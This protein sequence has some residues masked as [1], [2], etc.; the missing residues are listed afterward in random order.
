MLGYCSNVHAATTLEQVRAALSTHAVAVRDRLGIDGTLPLG[1]WLPASALDTVRDNGSG[2][3]KTW[4]EAHG[5]DVFTING[6]PFGDFH[7][8]VVKHAVYR[9]DWTDPQRP[10]Y[11]LALAELLA[12]LIEP[13]HSGGVS[14]VPLGW[15]PAMD[16][17]AI[18]AA[19]GRL[20]TIAADLERLEE[21]T[22]RCIHV[23]IEPE[24]GCAIERLDGLATFFERHLLGGDDADRIRRYLR[25]CVDCCHAA[26]MY[27]DLHD[28][29]AALD[30]RGIGIGKVQ[31]SNALDV[32]MSEDPGPSRVALQDFRDPRWLHQ[33]MVQDETGTR[34]HED[35][36]L[37][38]DAESGGR[39]R[40][41]FHVP[42]H[43]ERIGPLGTTR[44]LLEEAID[45]L[46]SRGEPLDWEVET[47][48]WPALP[49]SM[50]P[51]SLAEGIASE[52][53]WAR[54]RLADEGTR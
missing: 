2:G 24:P 53:Q 6:F 36:D 47:Y 14:T 54:S 19:A 10:A 28:G 4:L 20:R 8:D 23:D 52:L 25:A 3:L 37:A 11:T 17:D 1:L 51:D 7:G 35:L 32:D 39:W 26:V 9:P 34:F 44:P 43:V 50:Q 45:L 38:M 33:V 31:L 29:L 15:G 12:E 21:R 40:I 30:E 41:H 42:V 5:L 46:R 22:G 27:E 18:T 16:A 13:G 48:A 49:A